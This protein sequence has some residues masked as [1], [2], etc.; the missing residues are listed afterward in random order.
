MNM[1]L[2][3]SILDKL[4]GVAAQE[5]ARPAMVRKLK[6]DRA[7]K[8][9][10]LAGPG[11]RANSGDDLALQ[12]FHPLAAFRTSSPYR[13][14]SFD[15]GRI[16]SDIK[17]GIVGGIVGFVFANPN[18][19]IPSN[20]R[21]HLLV[22]STASIAATSS[23]KPPPTALRF[24]SRRGRKEGASR[25]HESHASNRVLNVNKR[26]QNRFHLLSFI[27]SNRDFSMGYNGFK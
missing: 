1:G 20:R 18:P 14:F 19:N 7:S 2:G 21:V 17:R 6:L 11:L 13:C 27:F 24:E 15:G 16:P 10:H 8:L 9:S 26:K 25:R 23:S 12:N 3:S 5:T 22:C 4:A